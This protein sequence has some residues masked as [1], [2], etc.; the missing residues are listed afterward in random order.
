MR[1]CEKQVYARKDDSE[2]P[3]ISLSFPACTTSALGGEL[4]L[5]YIPGVLL[6]QDYLTSREWQ[7]MILG[8]REGALP[9]ICDSGR[10]LSATGLSG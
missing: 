2:I 4:E 5:N 8:G 3:C 10:F 7:R 6:I 1:H 9:R